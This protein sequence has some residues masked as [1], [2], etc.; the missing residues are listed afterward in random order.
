MNLVKSLFIML[1][2]AW[3]IFVVYQGV[4]GILYSPHTYFYASVVLSALPLF[5]FLS[6]IFLF[7][8]TARTS[9]H[10]L[11]VSIPSFLGYVICFAL[12][13]EIADYYTIDGMIYSMSAFLLTLLYIYWYSNN[14]RK[15]SKILKIGDK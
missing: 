15:E 7:Q 10:L 8:S 5:L 9:L 4:L 14:A 2:P 3:L 12:F 13:L 1:T 6:F 11:I